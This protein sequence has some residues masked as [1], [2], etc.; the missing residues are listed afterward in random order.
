MPVSSHKPAPFELRITV[1]W[2]KPEPIELGSRDTRLVRDKLRFPPSIPPSSG[3]YRIICE[4]P[5]RPRRVYIGE[6][7]NLRTRA[8]QYAR[9]S[10]TRGNRVSPNRGLYTRLRNALRHNGSAQYQVAEATRVA[11]KGARTESL[12]MTDQFHRRLVEAA[13]LIHEEQRRDA[14]VINAKAPVAT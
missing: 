8:R 3:V 7:A 2:T 4:M 9:P 13:A 6:A 1:Q 5:G 12:K 10:D 14:E 11:Q